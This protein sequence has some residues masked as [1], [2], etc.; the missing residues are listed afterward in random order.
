[1]SKVNVM[2]G[3]IRTQ[4]TQMMSAKPDK[5]YTRLMLAAYLFNSW[6]VDFRCLVQWL[7]LGM[8]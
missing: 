2:H 6:I 5:D 1:M 7:W 4:R 8:T 3:L